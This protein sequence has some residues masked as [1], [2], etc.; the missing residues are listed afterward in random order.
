MNAHAAPCMDGSARVRRADVREGRQVVGVR[1]DAVGADRTVRV[2]RNATGLVRHL[3]AAVVVNQKVNT[4]AKGKITSI[5]L[6]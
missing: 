3:N 4:D 6:T 1:R 2:T 5:L